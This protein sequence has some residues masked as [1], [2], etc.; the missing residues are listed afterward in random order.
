VARA[1][2]AVETTLVSVFVAGGA[3]VR[4]TQVGGT[5]PAVFLIVAA[6]AIELGVTTAERVARQ[7][8][9][10]GVAVPAHEAMALAAVVD[11][12]AAARLAGVVSAV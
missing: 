9:I 6:G 2:L 4:Q 11:V 1:A 12:A 5:P 3:V 7:R 8:V 10:E